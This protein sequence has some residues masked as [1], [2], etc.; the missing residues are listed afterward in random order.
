MINNYLEFI[1]DEDLKQICLD[2]IVQPYYDKKLAAEEEIYDNV[3]DPFSAILDASLSKRTLGEWLHAE[4]ARQL[5]KTLQN[6][7]GEFHQCIIGALEGWEDLGQGKVLD[8]INRDSGIIAEI[9]NKWN[10][11]KGNHKVRIYEDIEELLAGKYPDY[12]GYYVEI[13]PKSPTPYNKTF[14]PPDNQ[15]KTRK[16]E[17]EDIRVID[18]KSFYTMATGRESAILELYTALPIVIRDIYFEDFGE[19]IE[20]KIEDETEF[21]SLFKRAY[22]NI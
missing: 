7:I 2:R 12:T 11:T 14:T 15:T 8:V 3:L 21:E 22:G 9:K 5:Q 17:R 4:K 16:P 20:D 1:E 6:H 13:V 10:T 18:G 19:A